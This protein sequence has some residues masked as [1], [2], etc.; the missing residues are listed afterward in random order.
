MIWLAALDAVMITAIHANLDGGD[1]R[2]DLLGGVCDICG[3]V[4]GDVVEFLHL[5]QQI[6]RTTSM[7]VVFYDAPYLLQF[8]HG[9]LPTMVVIIVSFL[10]PPYLVD[11]A[12]IHGETTIGFSSLG[13]RP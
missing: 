4:G 9:F 12:N 7:T 13:N 3:H 2:I 6:A 5:P 10:F 1:R 8:V 11:D